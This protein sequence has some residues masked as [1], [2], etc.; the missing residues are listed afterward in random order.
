MAS[1]LAA[2]YSRKNIGLTARAQA[3]E[4]ALTVMTRELGELRTAVD[5]V[6]SAL[7]VPPLEENGTTSATARIRR[8]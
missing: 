6:G 8:I 3:A 5:E 7:G 1:N 4:K 2:S